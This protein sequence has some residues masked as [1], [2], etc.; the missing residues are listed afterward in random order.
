MMV[1]MEDVLGAIEQAN[2]PGT[3]REQP[4]WLRRLDLPLEQWSQHKPLCDLARALAE[5]RAP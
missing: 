2:V 4:N 1:Q 5:D 3:V